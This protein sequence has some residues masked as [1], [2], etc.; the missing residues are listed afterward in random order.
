MRYSELTEAPKAPSMEEKIRSLFDSNGPIDWEV[1]KN[2]IGN[3]QVYWSYTFRRNTCA[4]E[5]HDSRRL[6]DMA[7]DRLAQIGSR[8]GADAVLAYRPLTLEVC[9]QMDQRSEENGDSAYSEYEQAFGGSILLKSDEKRKKAR[10]GR[11]EHLDI[12][13]KLMKLNG[14]KVGKNLVFEVKDD[15]ET[16]TISWKL[17]FKGMKP[18]QACDTYK[19]QIAKAEEL[20][21]KVL[22]KY[23]DQALDMRRFDARNERD[24]DRYVLP[25]E[26]KNEHRI[27][28]SMSFLRALPTKENGYGHYIDKNNAR[29][30]TFAKPQA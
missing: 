15:P 30:A 23:N 26:V 13:E 8:F 17:T 1:R 29:K 10:D 5:F 20:M 2:A 14:K 12:G 9:K 6:V 4:G 16:V 21:Q 19:D 28:S 18:G 25:H 3:Y 22:V 27:R 7:N 11:K 24:L